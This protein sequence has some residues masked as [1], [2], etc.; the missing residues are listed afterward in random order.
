MASHSWPDRV[1]AIGGVRRTYDSAGRFCCIRFSV[2]RQVGE[3]YRFTYNP[4]HRWFYFPRMERNEVVLL[5]CYDSKEDGRAR[6]TAHTAFEDP[7][8]PL[9]ARHAK[10]LKCALSCF[11]RRN[12]NLWMFEPAGFPQPRT[13]GRRVPTP[14]TSR[15]CAQVTQQPEGHFS[16]LDRL[17]ASNAR[18]P[19]AGQNNGRPSRRKV[20]SARIGLNLIHQRLGGF[21]GC[22]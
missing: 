3:T 10:V 19:G 9:N 14:G 7:T 5:K 4:G 1:N 8:S 21:G 15:G 17:H 12:E 6:F 22:L 13:Q 2:S 18:R 16:V 11:G 20:P